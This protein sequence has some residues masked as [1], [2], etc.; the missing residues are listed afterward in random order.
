MIVSERPERRIPSRITT[1]RES[2]L[3]NGAS[4]STALIE[5]Q[6]FQRDRQTAESPRVAAVA[7]VGAGLRGFLRCCVKKAPAWYQRCCSI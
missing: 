6:R 2:M 4:V 3:V 7:R 5:N 1:I